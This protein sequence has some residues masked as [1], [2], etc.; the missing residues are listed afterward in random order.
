M[1][2]I[3]FL[4]PFHNGD[5]F[6]SKEYVR[7]VIKELPGFEFGYY[8]NNH[9]KTL[10][11]LGIPHLGPTDIFGKK[12]KHYPAFIEN[13]RS[14]VINTWIGLTRR[15]TETYSRYGSG[16]SH[17]TLGQMWQVI[18][19]KINQKF[20]TNLKIK[21]KSNYVANIDFSFFNLT[22][23]DTFL[24]NNNK[25][26][27]IS[28][29]APKSR[30]SFDSDMKD[31][32][33]KLSREFQDWLFIC[34]NKFKTDLRNIIFTDDIIESESFNNNPHPWNRKI[35]DLNEISYLSQHCDIIVGKNSGPF[36]YC[37]TKNNVFNN[38]KSII[39]FNKNE[40]D[41]L[42]WNIDHSCRYKWSGNYEDAS[43]FE[44]IKA[45]LVIS[46]L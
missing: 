3:Y 27:L 9:E 25:K 19:E 28:N 43:V 24:K 2:K 44:I 17:D 34:T 22:S 23:V 5:L 29:G 42:L 26:I 33:E 39:S 40:K 13:K 4:Q 7:Q 11:D 16:I 18:F 12:Y 41:S 1:N 20:K 37:I 30:Q 45:E 31:V 21:D 8:H 10:R 15:D 46:S 38:Q 6:V 14:L 35:C 32:I 36:I